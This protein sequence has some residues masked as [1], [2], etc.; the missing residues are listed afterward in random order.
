MKVT[1][2]AIPEVLVAEPKVFGDNRGFF[3]ESSNQAEFGKWVGEILS[4]DS[5]KQLWVQEGFAHGFLVL[6]E[7]AKFFYQATHYYASDFKRN[8]VLNDPAIAIQWSIES[9]PT[10]S[11]KDQQAKI[12]AILES[13][14]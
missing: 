13:F 6:S 3:F 5:K 14:A 11:A 12:L 10:L 9:E 1:L 4:A 7:T 2:T 8:I